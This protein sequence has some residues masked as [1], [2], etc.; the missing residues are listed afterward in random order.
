MRTPD[1]VAAML[2]L[3]A[4]GWGAKRIA[5]EFGCSRKTVRRYLEAGRLG[6]LPQAARGRRRWTGWRT[7]WRSG[8]GSIAAMPTWC[9]RSCWPST[10]IAVSLRTVE[11]A[12]APSAPGAARP[13]R[14]RRCGSRRR[15]AGSC[16]ST[17]ARRRVDDRR[18]DGAGVSCSWRRSATRAGC[19]CGRS[20]TS[21]RRPGSTGWRAPSGTS[22]GCR[23]RCCSTTPRALVE[24]H[25][26]ATREVRFNAR[27]LALRQALG[28]PA[29][30]LRALPGADQGQGRARRRLCEAQRDCRPC[31]R[32]LGGAG[33]ASGLVDARDS[34]PAGDTLL[35]LGPPGVGKTH[36]AIA[37]GREAIREG[38]SVLFVVGDPAWL[39]PR[40]GASGGPL[41]RA[42]SVLCKAQAADR[43]GAGLPAVLAQRG[44]PV[45][46]AR[47]P[48]LRARQ[49]AGHVEP[50]GRRMGRGLRRSGRGHSH[51]RPAAASQPCHHDP[52][53]Q[54]PPAREA[55]CRY[56]QLSQ[57]EPGEGS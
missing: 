10:G 46:P 6:G 33:G 57:P 21:A 9:G 11:R 35:L 1:E 49:S 20:G 44:A 18:R 5:A 42:A 25:D 22:A 7:G 38:Y 29:A 48:T 47:L 13:R 51:P 55:P 45:L 43:R 16:R 14:G 28:L 41:R 15:P 54:L 32:E 26:A 12:V 39:P 3:Q 56:L 19:M 36:L 2:R 31:L 52:R 8:S 23:R 24:H 27:L 40:Q 34:R 53:R 4:L 30:G 17:S 37:L 50:V